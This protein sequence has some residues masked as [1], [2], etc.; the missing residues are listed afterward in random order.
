MSNHESKLSLQNYR[1]RFESAVFVLDND[2]GIYSA[3][4]QRIELFKATPNAEYKVESFSFATNIYQDDFRQALLSNKAITNPEVFAGV[5]F[6]LVKGSTNSPINIKRYKLFNYFGQYDFNAYF[7]GSDG[8]GG[9]QGIPQ[10]LSSRGES[11]YIQLNA[12]L[13]QTSLMNTQGID[14]LALYFS[15]VIKEKI[16]NQGY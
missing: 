3:V 2:S 8:I 15:F 6:D 16:Q 10:D 9:Q 14:K 7:K 11:I 12:N 5:Q 4:G 13:N 1:T